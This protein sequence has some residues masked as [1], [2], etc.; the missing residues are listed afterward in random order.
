[1]PKQAPDNFVTYERER[2]LQNSTQTS[3][4][5]NIRSLDI[6]M[7]LRFKNK[8]AWKNLCNKTWTNP[9]VLTPGIF[10][11]V[12]PCP[13]KSVYGFSL[14]IKAESP[15]YIFDIVTTRFESDYRPDWVYDASRKAKEFGMSREP[16]I[17]SEFHIVSRDILC[18]HILLC[19]F[20]SKTVDI[21]LKRSFLKQGP[22]F[23]NLAQLYIYIIEK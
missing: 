12:C 15:S 1:M 2:S 18:S 19:D 14:M 16:D 7:Q 17:Y 20:I 6:P 3:N 21:W 13:K 9:K 11:V 23:W 4:M 8:S 5:S 22:N 10:L